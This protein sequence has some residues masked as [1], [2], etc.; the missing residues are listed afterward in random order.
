MNDNEKQRA[1]ILKEKVKMML[2]SSIY[3][4]IDKIL[5]LIDLVQR[6]GISYHFQK[7]INHALEQIHNTLT[8]D[9]II[10]EEVNHNSL[11]LLFRLLRQHGYRISSGMC[12]TLSL[13]SK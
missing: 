12:R 2:Q 9:N 5:N 8:R 10:R 7:E 3:Q 13:I 4:N 6:F 1:Q 11:A